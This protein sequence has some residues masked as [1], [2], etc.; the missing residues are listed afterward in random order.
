[1]ADTIKFSLEYASQEEANTGTDNEK[2]M[3]PLRTAQAIQELSEAGTSV[4][5]FENP[6]EFRPFT[7]E[8][9]FPFSPGYTAYSTG[10]LKVDGPE[11][12]QEFAQSGQEL[13]FNITLKGDFL[14]LNPN[15]FLLSVVQYNKEKELTSTYE[16][17]GHAQNSRTTSLIEVTNQNV[18]EVSKDIDYSTPFAYK[19]EDTHYV[20]FVVI[21]LDTPNDDFINITVPSLSLTSPKVNGRDIEVYPDFHKVKVDHFGNIFEKSD[22]SSSSR[23]FNPLPVF[24]IGNSEIVYH[25]EVSPI[26]P[27]VYRDKVLFRGQVDASAP[28]GLELSLRAGETE[29]YLYKATFPLGENV[30]FDITYDDCRAIVG[31]GV[32]FS[33]VDN[34]RIKFLQAASGA[35]AFTNC[36]L[37]QDNEPSPYTESEA[38]IF[39]EDGVVSGSKNKEQVVFVDNPFYLRAIP[40]GSN[41]WNRITDFIPINGISSVPDEEGNLTC[42]S[43]FVDQYQSRLAPTIHLYDENF[44]LIDS[45][46]RPPIDDDGIIE[47][48][49]T[50]T[51]FHIT[52]IDVSIPASYIKIEISSA[53]S[54]PFL[55]NNLRDLV[56]QG[57]SI[58]NPALQEEFTFTKPVFDKYGKLIRGEQSTLYFVV[59]V[60]ASDWVGAEPATVVKTA[61][62]LLNTDKPIFDID[63]SNVDF[64][65]VELKQTEYSK[66]YRVS[67]TDNDEIT[68][69]ALS[70]PTEDLTIQIRVVR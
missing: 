61:N 58:E 62:G 52:N 70:A 37:F 40:S 8:P 6:L 11:L 21:F 24:S 44:D 17:A 56:V 64:A 31:S 33:N 23:F 60:L 35:P 28:G 42:I 13:I 30:R 65:D 43:F 63:L 39:D 66:L 50:L 12:Q 47:T 51:N 20:K 15:P 4:E 1:M 18:I 69:Y 10:F 2:L 27:T 49:V 41:M 53:S 26:T 16:V 5:V 45:R 48:E 67:A 22:I 57:V 68:F 14:G 59:D 25:K 55:V 9:N 36:Y 38:I 54:P 19:F 46:G 29:V 32:D 34:L 7:D 3:T